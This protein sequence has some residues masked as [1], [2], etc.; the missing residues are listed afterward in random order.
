MNRQSYVA[1]A[2]LGLL[3]AAGAWCAASYGPGQG[4]DVNFP[5]TRPGDVGA[6]AAEVATHTSETTVPLVVFTPPPPAHGLWAVELPDGRRLWQVGG[7]IDARPWIAGD[8]V[9]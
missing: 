8:V 5:D 9:V 4:F 3:A 6:V 2:G 7:R 1:C